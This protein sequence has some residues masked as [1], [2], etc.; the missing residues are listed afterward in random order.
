MITSFIERKPQNWDQ[1]LSILT[2]AYRSTVHPATGYTP[3]FLMFGREVTLPV[4]ILFPPPGVSQQP[5]PVEYVHNLRVLLE[6]VYHHVRKCL[7]HAAE[8]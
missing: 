6:D 3:N 2:A 4:D 8:V 7:R 1:Y 5:M